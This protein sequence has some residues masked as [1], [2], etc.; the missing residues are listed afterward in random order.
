MEDISP[1]EGQKILERARKTMQEL[2]NTRGHRYGQD[3]TNPFQTDC[4]LFNAIALQDVVGDKGEGLS[5]RH[6]DGNC[7]FRRL[8]PGEA[9]RAGDALA[10]PRSSGPPGSQHTGIATG[11]TTSN[12]GYT[13]VAMGNSGAREGSVWGRPMG[14]NDG[15]FEG[16]FDLHAY[17]PQKPC[18]KP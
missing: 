11:S 1:E 9:P 4:T 8:K 12:G 6:Y 2:T 18:K 13:G 15:W 7:L 10:Q 5:S 3:R 17:R 14:K 16:G